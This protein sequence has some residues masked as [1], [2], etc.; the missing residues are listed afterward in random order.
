MPL[1]DLPED[2]IYI[3]PQAI[4]LYKA[5]PFIQGV[6]GCLKNIKYDI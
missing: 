3:F 5:S 1:L 2:P 6:P 4:S